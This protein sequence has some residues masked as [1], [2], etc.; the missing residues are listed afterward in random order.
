VYDLFLR[1]LEA[2]FPEATEADLR[3]MLAKRHSMSQVTTPNELAVKGRKVFYYRSLH[4]KGNFELSSENYTDWAWVPRLEL[5][6]Y[7]T[8]ERYARL[9]DTLL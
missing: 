2:L 9:V 5:N 6:K 4:V 1:R 8:R 3:V 7:L